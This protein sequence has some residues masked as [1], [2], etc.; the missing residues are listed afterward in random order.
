MFDLFEAF[1]IFENLKDFKQDI[2]NKG[3]R[4]QRI[5]KLERNLRTGWTWD[6]KAKYIIEDK[7]KIS[8]YEDLT[9]LRAFTKD[10]ILLFLKLTK[11]EILDIIEETK[12]M[13]IVARKI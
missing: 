9:T 6:W 4:I 11:F 8:E 13:N 5:S 2:W 7:G 12:A 10:E 3:K 1:G